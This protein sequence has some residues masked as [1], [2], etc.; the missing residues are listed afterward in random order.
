MASFALTET[1]ILITV[2]PSELRRLAD[3]VENLES[4]H[5]NRKAGESTVADQWNYGNLTLTFCYDQTAANA[6]LKRCK[7]CDL[8]NCRGGCFRD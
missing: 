4:Q 2:T 8:Q 5:W 3:K 7:L 1:E 6:A